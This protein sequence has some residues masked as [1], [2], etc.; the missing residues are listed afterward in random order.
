MTSTEFDVVVETWIKKITGFIS[1]GKAR[2]LHARLS[3]DG[4][5]MLR[6]H[7]WIGEAGALEKIS[8]IITENKKNRSINFK[9]AVC[10]LLLV[11]WSLKQ[12]ERSY[13]RPFTAVVETRI[14]SIR[15]IL[16]NKAKEYARDD[17]LY[18]FKRAA[19]IARTTPS[20]ALIGMMMKHVVSVVDLVEGT[21][22]ATPE[23]VDEKIGDLIN[24][25]ILLDALYKEEETVAA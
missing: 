8:V 16:A 12:V 3:K 25:L 18:N 21:L 9:R 17:R 7:A 22:K 24:Y 23:M 5:K 19:E 1:V 11:E 2:I 20:K 10:N 4:L 6:W 15:S 14:A 13:Y